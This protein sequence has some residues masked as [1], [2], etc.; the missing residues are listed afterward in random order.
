MDGGPSAQARGTIMLPNTHLI[1]GTA[2]E[3]RNGSVLM[4]FRT[5]VGAPPLAQPAGASDPRACCVD[6][7]PSNTPVAQAGC[8]YSSTS[9]DKG[10][11]WSPTKPMAIPNPNSKVHLMRMEPSGARVLP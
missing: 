5:Q 2:A 11:T 4:I 10:L 7:P 3:M 8:L 9:D 1:E 6:P